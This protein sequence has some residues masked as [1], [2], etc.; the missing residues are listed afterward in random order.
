MTWSTPVDLGALA[1]IAHAA[2][3]AVAVG[4]P[5]RAAFAF[6]GTTTPDSNYDMPEFAGVWY[7][8]VASTFDGGAT[9]TKLKVTM[10]TLDFRDIDAVDAHTAF[11]LSIGNGG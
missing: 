2:F 8:Y 5:D 4:D 6:F 9:W 7:L 11:V 10:D 1:G 3:P